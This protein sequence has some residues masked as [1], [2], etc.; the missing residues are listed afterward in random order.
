MK[1]AKVLLEVL[2]RFNKHITIE[3]INGYISLEKVT[4]DGIRVGQLF[5]Y[6]F[7]V[8]V[9]IDSDRFNAINIDATY[10]LSFSNE[11]EVYPIQHYIELDEEPLNTFDDIG[12]GKQFFRHGKRFFKVDNENAINFHTKEK[13]SFVLST[14]CIVYEEEV[15]FCRCCG[16]PVLDG[17]RDA[18]DYYCSDKCLPYSEDEWENKCEEN[19]DECYWIEVE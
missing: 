18:D 14:Y 17:Y 16:K 1:N 13:S 10:S 4:F 8:Y 5:A 9:K 12:V 15:N 7:D 6:M 11:D 2:N 3:T 19:E